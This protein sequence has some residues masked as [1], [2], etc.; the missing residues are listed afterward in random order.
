[1]GLFARGERG[2]IEAMARAVEPRALVTE[3]AVRDGRLVIEL[4]V[5][6]SAEPAPE[7]EELAFMR[8]STTLAWAFDTSPA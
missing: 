4:G 2:G 8:L 6:Q 7:P 3:V 5:D 1:L